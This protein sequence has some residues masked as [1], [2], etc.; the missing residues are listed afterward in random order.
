[1]RLVSRLPLILTALA[2]V[3][4][5]TLVYLLAA[6][7]AEYD[8]SPM[9]KRAAVPALSLPEPFV[10]PPLAEV[11]DIEERPLFVPER[12]PFRE[13]VEA[14][15]PEP[16]RR[17]EATLVGVILDGKRRIAIAKIGGKSVHLVPGA[18]VE[19]WSVVAIEAD[20]VAFKADEDSYEIRLPKPIAAPPAQPRPATPP[21]P[22][23]MPPPPGYAPR[24]EPGRP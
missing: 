7:A 12:R 24:Q 18:N 3:L 4:A 21:R 16:R 8:V 15:P 2:S 10:P 19:G 13:Q 6:P 23:R 5:A 22:P 11:A 9:P 20:R 17:P 14:P 1:M